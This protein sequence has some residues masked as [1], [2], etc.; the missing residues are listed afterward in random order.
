MSIFCTG[1]NE[2]WVAVMFG[3]VHL[4]LLALLGLGLFAIRF[5]SLRLPY[6]ALLLACLSALPIQAHLVATGN[7]HC[8]VP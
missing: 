8:D 7:L 1:P 5:W 3:V 6:A 2:S 4:T